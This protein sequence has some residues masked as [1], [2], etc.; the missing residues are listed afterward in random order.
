MTSIRTWLFGT[1]S[2]RVSG[3]T[4]SAF[5]WYQYCSESWWV[6]SASR[7]RSWYRTA[8]PMSP[9]WEPAAWVSQAGAGLGDGR[10]FARR[11]GSAR[12]G[13]GYPAAP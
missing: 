3:V 12:V 6:W 10:V 7:A 13:L 4:K 2:A 5:V 1:E 9:L 8:E 11:P